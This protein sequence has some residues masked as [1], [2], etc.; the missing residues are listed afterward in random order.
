[1]DSFEKGRSLVEEGKYK[2][3]VEVLNRVIEQNKKDANP[4]VFRGIAYIY[5]E[6]YQ[7]AI[8]D[9]S[10]AIKR[11]SKN[12]EAYFNRGYAYAK[13]NEYQKAIEDYK[14]AARLDLKEACDF[15]MSRGIP[16]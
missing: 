8:K 14:V 6:D 13:L 1:M 15:L 10:E 9:C 12:A 3:A 2:E 11:D 16:W 5:L 7:Q 4:L